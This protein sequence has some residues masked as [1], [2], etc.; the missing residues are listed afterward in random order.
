MDAD[1]G[2]MLFITSDDTESEL[3]SESDKLSTSGLSST[4]TLTENGTSTEIMNVA[5]IIT[6]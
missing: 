4:P 5:T 6:P 3:E 1:V 2:C